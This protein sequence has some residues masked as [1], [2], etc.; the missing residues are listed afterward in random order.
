MDISYSRPA[1]RREIFKLAWPTIIE[2]MLI[3]LVGIVSTI[4]V[5]RLGKESMAAVGMVNN[6]M[7]FFQTLFAGL[8]TGTTIVV[9]RVTGESGVAKAKNTLMQS[10]LMGAVVGVVFTAI[11]L[12][13]SD[14]IIATFFGG[15]EEQVLHYSRLYY[16]IIL[17]SVPFWVLDMIIAGA[18]RGAG[19]T[20]TP[21]YVTGIVNVINAVLSIVLI[22]GF[23]LGVLAIPALGVKGA[24]LAVMAARICGCI[25]RIGL[26]FWEGSKI[27][28]T[29]K[30]RF[31]L[32]GKIM[33]RIVKVGVPSFTENLIMQG[34]FLLIQILVVSIGTSETA[35]YQ[36][37]GNIHSL[38][39]MPIWG[40][41][42]T[43]TTTVGQN[44]GKKEY[45]TA[46]V[47][48]YENKRLAIWVGIIAGLFE[49]ILAKPL[50][51]MYTSD[52]EVIR[53][54]MLVVRGFA[55][56]EPFMGIEKISAA[57]IRS[58]GD[59]RYILITG[60]VALWSF[61][62]VTAYGLNRLLD[63]GLYGI[64]IG[65]FLDFSVRAI[66]YTYRMKAGKWKYLKI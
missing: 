57:A 64:M 16:K 59:I 62:I 54:S 32:D 19:D 44:L 10:I 3:M 13:L 46:E 20:R 49:F 66:M 12:L 40:F 45:D 26:L 41:A 4:F 36:I 42:I 47:F 61:R 63:L 5:A 24:A 55:L 23:N 38:A 9:A 31:K 21:L 51:A 58:A 65:I 50:S 35:A 39:F 22:F 33:K 53:A 18:L 7:N 60:I 8:S 34:G 17:I 43:T 2:Q 15:A 52:P 37:G 48:A 29:I 30:D 6:L 14:N 56:I 28:L 11:N 25:M 1:V 27:N